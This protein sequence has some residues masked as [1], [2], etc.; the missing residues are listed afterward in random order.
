MNKMEEKN[1]NEEIE[2][3]EEIVNEAIKK[4]D[5]DVMPFGITDEE[6]ESGDNNDANK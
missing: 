5:E 1:I 6:I 3:L 2:A 4:F